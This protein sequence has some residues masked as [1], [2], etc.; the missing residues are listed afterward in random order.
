MVFDTFTAANTANGFFSYFDELVNDRNLN[1][2]YLIKGG[3]GS[4]K[5]TFMKKCAKHFESK[6]YSIERIRCSSDPDS[7]DGIKV[8]KKGIVII[9][10]TSP[11][12]YDMKYPGAVHSLI[13]LS[14]FWDESI[15]SKSRQTVIELFDEISSGYK[16][17]YDLLS[18]AGST[19]QWRAGMIADKVDQDKIRGCIKKI[20]TQNAVTAVSHKPKI[21]NRMLSAIGKDGVF[22]LSKTTDTLCNEYIIFEDSCD[23]AHILL[24]KA[25]YHFNKMGYDTILIHSPLMPL[26]RLEQVIIPQ[27]KIGLISAKHLFSPET[28][29]SK[30][31]KKIN[32]KTFIDKAFYSE[33]KNKLGFTKKLSKELILKAANEISQIKAKHDTLEKHYISAMDFDALNQFTNEF[34]KKF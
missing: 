26:S 34:I 19:E 13:D 12:S 33:N 5:S 9:D 2:V 7:L 15:L 16:K 29:E 17:V 14:K 30:T 6:G 24:S 18:A 28:D 31:I 8:F 22:T 11:H 27:L 25:A 20:I 3:P 1:R 10:A 23:I 32:T 21:T 4:G